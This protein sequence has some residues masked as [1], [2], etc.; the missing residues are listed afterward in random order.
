LLIWCWER[1]ERHVDV[2]PISLS[3]CSREESWM[4]K[5]AG[6]L[7]VCSSG[8]WN[9]AEHLC[10]VNS[11]PVWPPQNVPGTVY[12]HPSP[13]SL[14]MAV[15]SA[16]NVAPFQLNSS[17]VHILC[18][19]S[20]YTFNILVPHLLPVRNNIWR[21]LLTSINQVQIHLYLEF[22][23]WALLT[24]YE[25]FYVNFC[26]SVCCM[27]MRIFFER[28]SVSIWQYSSKHKKYYKYLPAIDFSTE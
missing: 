28:F 24:F 15:T 2:K 3:I 9:S 25:V 6:L 23:F 22:L 19:S 12:M 27:L 21:V 7:S 8:A 4:L 18:S 1:P 16:V 13:L 14:L 26:Q 5:I 17:P 11:A 10:H 20:T